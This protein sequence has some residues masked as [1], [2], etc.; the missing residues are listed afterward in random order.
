MRFFKVIIGCD[1]YKD[2][3]KESI[4]ILIIKYLVYGNFESRICTRDY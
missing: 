1:I 3:V 4:D 2:F